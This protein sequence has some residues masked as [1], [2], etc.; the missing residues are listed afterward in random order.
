MLT[1]KKI[2]LAVT[3][4][5][6]AYKTPE[7]VRQL[8]KQGAEVQVLMTPAAADFVSPLALSTVSKKPV[9]NS[10]SNNDQWHN[11]VHLGRWADVL[12]IAPCSA[13]T[14]AKMAN[15]LCDNMVQAVYLSATCP[16]LI[17]PAMDEDMWLHPATEANVKK[18]AAYG[19]QIIAPEHGELASGI[20]GA[21]RMADPEHIVQFIADFFKKKDTPPAPSKFKKAL[22]TAGPTYEKLDPVRFIGNYSS[23]KMGIALAKTLAEQGV[24]VTLVLGPTKEEVLLP[25]ITLL[26]VESAQEMFDQCNAVFEDIDLVIMSAAVADFRPATQAK[27]KIK[28]TDG[29]EHITIEL[30]K[31]PDILAT[32]GKKKT[33]QVLVGFALETNNELAHA[34]AKLDKKNADF[35]VLNSLNDKGAGFGTDTNKVTIISHNNQ[36]YEVPLQSKTAIAL[37][38]INYISNA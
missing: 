34:Q 30:V 15:G 8:V 10:V 21:G 23:G 35:I 18:V 7:L 25:N 12:L 38:I 19:N 26:R 32:L 3:G 20:I 29:A 24:A 11:H 22:I 6:A 17:A 16:V 1:N 13:N 33:H 28:K 37:A 4:S 27:E 5:I 2:I 14:L 36:P 31:N 9:F